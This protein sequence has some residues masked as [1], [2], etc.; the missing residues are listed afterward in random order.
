M[1]TLRLS[2]IAPRS[3]LVVYIRFMMLL[4]HF[5]AKLLLF[6]HSPCTLSLH[7]KKRFSGFFFV[8]IEFVESSCCSFKAAGPTLLPHP[9]LWAWRPATA[10]AESL[11]V[12]SCVVTQNMAAS[13]IAST[14]WTLYC[15]RERVGRDHASAHTYVVRFHR[16]A[17]VTGANETRSLAASE[18]KDA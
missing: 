8:Q 18:Q 9:L 3:P 1:L 2:H 12:H 14:C 4:K 16:R 7:C 15:A 17:A 6:V 10:A 11:A 13:R 5:C